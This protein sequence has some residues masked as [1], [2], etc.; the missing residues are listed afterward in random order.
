MLSLVLVD[1]PLAPEI[2]KACEGHKV[3]MNEEYFA[4]DTVL[5]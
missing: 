1:H 5:L 2:E 4:P 3:G